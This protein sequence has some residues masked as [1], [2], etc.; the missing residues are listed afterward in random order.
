MSW[1]FD[2]KRIEAEAKVLKLEKEVNEAKLALN[3]L[4][5]GETFAVSEIRKVL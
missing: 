2:T 5:N 1:I 4:N 3:R